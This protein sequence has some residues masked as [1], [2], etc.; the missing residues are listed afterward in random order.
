SL[1]NCR[2]GQIPRPAQAEPATGMVSADYKADFKNNAARNAARPSRHYS[3]ATAS[4]RE[5]DGR[6]RNPA[7]WRVYA[8]TID[9]DSVCK[10]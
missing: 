5:W 4:I 1:L 7:Q 3:V 2:I 9:R 10:K 6:N 8:N